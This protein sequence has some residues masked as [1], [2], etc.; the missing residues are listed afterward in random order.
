MNN[1]YQLLNEVDID[2]S[3]Y[4][5][6]E[7]SAH[8]IKQMKRAFR[9]SRFN[10]AKS[11]KIGIAIAMT[12]IIGFALLIMPMAGKEALA[13]IFG[14]S[15]EEFIHYRTSTLQDYKTVVNRT[16]NQDGV[17]V[18]LNEVAIDNNQI[19]VSS[20]FQAE[21]VKWAE[22]SSVMPNIYINGQELSSNGGT[23][24]AI[25][26]DNNTCSFLSSIHLTKDFIKNGNLDMK[27]EFNEIWGDT[28]K[29]G[30]WA[31][32]FYTSKD[33]LSGK[34]KTITINKEILLG[35]GNTISVDNLKLSPISTVL[36]F[37]MK[38]QD[39]KDKSYDMQFI[40]QD[41]NGNEL[42]WVSGST[43]LKSNFW[44]YETLNEKVTKLKITPVTIYYGKP[45]QVG[46]HEYR[47][48]SDH[49]TILKDQAFE[50]KIK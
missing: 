26:R 25:V 37:T 50:I 17:A 32:E 28:H 8:E 13:N 19:L 46:D 9:K 3:N 21:G 30:N 40:V 36:N 6:Y 41:Q 5:E 33:N 20:T 35:Q 2:F 4:P 14:I 23:C 18:T 7:L 22:S 24:K 10:L 39:P 11:Y 16:I 49:K 1:I 27:I 38:E 42:K 45:Q 47:Q 29:K 48:N 44:I 15:I 43:G 31:F 12:L 34:V